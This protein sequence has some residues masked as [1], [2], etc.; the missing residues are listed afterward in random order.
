M[1]TSNG[2]GN[3]MKTFEPQMK[4]L[5]NHTTEVTWS[6]GR[7]TILSFYRRPE[8]MV[9]PKKSCWNMVFLALSGKMIFLLPAYM[10]LH[11]RRKMKDDLSLKNIRKYDIFFKLSEKMIFSKRTT[12]GHDLSCIIWKDGIF[13][14]R[15]WYFFSWAESQRWPFSRNTWKYDIFCVHVRALQTL[16]HTPLSKKIRDGLITQKYSERWLTF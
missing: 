9:F 8:N 10:I 11:F 16:R 1:V 15:T 4:I 7:K 14:P 12:L 13:F 2:K 6:T 5:Q 3:P